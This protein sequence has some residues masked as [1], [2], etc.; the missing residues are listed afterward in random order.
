MLKLQIRLLPYKR[1]YNEQAMLLKVTA[2]GT[3]LSTNYR[4]KQDTD[5]K[6]YTDF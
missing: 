6:I 3:A 5:L 1:T 4:T 2:A